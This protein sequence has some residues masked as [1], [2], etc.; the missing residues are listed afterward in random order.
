MNNGQRTI[1]ALL[2]VIAVLLGLNIVAKESPAA[3]G[4]AAAEMQEP[5][6]VAMSVT[7]IIGDN[8]AGI[9]QWR[10][11]RLWS[12]GGIDTTLATFVGPSVGGCDIEAICPRQL[13]PGTCTADI[14]HNGEVEVNDFLEVLGQWGPCP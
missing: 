5:V 4:Q 12:D 1:P 7:Q 11:F 6:P 10:A 8:G 13:L 9:R 2:A 3:M 14:T